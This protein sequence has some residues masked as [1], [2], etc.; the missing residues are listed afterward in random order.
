MLNILLLVAVFES[1]TLRGVCVVYVISLYRYM[2]SHCVVNAT[3]VLI[4]FLIGRRFPHQKAT[5]ATSRSTG[6]GEVWVCGRLGLPL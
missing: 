1:V 4:D 3:T 5:A 6:E 2:V